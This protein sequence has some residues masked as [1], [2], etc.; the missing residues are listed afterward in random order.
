MCGITGF[1]GSVIDRDKVIRNMTDV[2]THRGPDSSGVYQDDEISMGFRRLSIID[3]SS[4]GDQPI[5]NEDKTLV[6]TFNGEIYNYRQLKEELLG[7]G[8]SFYTNTDTEVIVHGYEQWGKDVLNKLRGMFA[9]IIFD[10]KN[11]LIFGARDFF[12][13]KPF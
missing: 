6:L 1:T 4:T 13:I 9:F 8:H 3:I 12:G 7:F 5:Y 2:I 10:K 11:D